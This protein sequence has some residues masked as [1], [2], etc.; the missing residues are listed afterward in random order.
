MFYEI[1]KGKLKQIF[2][3]VSSGVSTITREDVLS[4]FEALFDQMVVSFDIDKVTNEDY[5]V[6]VENYK[7]VYKEF[8]DKKRLDDISKEELQDGKL[9]SDLCAKL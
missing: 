6:I 9:T 4:I 7:C 1:P 2:E 5:E 3:V 8:N